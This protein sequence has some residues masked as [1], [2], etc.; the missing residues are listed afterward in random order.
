MTKDDLLEL[1]KSWPDC[2]CWDVDEGCERLN[3][4]EVLEALEEAIEDLPDDGRGLEVCIREAWP[5]SLT[6][7]GW[8]RKKVS[9]EDIQ[10]MAD[11]ATRAVLEYFSETLEMSDPD[12]DDGEPDGLLPEGFKEVIRKDMEARHIWGCDQTD[13]IELTTDQVVDIARLEWPEWF[14]PVNEPCDTKN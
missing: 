8:T 1:A 12:D 13:E 9:E 4:S 2:D 3:H 5:E 6:I 10:T 7:Y 14:E 11:E